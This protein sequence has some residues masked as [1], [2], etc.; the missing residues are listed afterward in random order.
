MCVYAC[1]VRVCVRISAYFFVILMTI[2]GVSI[3]GIQ[4]T[5]MH[6]CTCT[7]TSVARNLNGKIQTWQPDL[8]LEKWLSANLSVTT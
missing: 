7:C 4:L 3:E 2:K 5:Y 6:A 8:S 1:G